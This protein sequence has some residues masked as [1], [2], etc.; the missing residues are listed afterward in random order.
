MKT[1][2]LDKRFKSYDGMEIEDD[3]IRV[4]LAKALFAG[5]GVGES[6]DD[7]FDAYCLCNKLSSS[8]G[9]LE[10]SDREREILLNAANASLRPG[11]FGQVADL[12]D[13][14]R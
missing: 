13:Y 7:K 2:N 5:N 11:A 3:N 8:S 12:L 9:E 1:V 6:R 4:T 10:I 14:K